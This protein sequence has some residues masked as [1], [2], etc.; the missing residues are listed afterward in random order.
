MFPVYRTDRMALPVNQAFHSGTREFQT[1]R[2]KRAVAFNEQNKINQ[3]DPAFKGLVPDSTGS[4]ATPYTQNFDMSWKPLIPRREQ[5]MAL[6]E[7]E[8][9][10]RMMETRAAISGGFARSPQGQ[11][12]INERLKQKAA[13]ATKL[14]NPFVLGKRIRKA[15][16][17][18]DFGKFELAQ[19]LTRLDNTMDTLDA[20]TL[21][22]N[23]EVSDVID[24]IR[25]NLFLLAPT[26]TVAEAQNIMDSIGSILKKAEALFGDVIG[27]DSQ[28]LYEMGEEYSPAKVSTDTKKLAT[29]VTSIRKL[30]KFAEMIYGNASKTSEA[31]RSSAAIASANTLFSK[32]EIGSTLKTAEAEIERWRTTSEQDETRMLEDQA[33]AEA[34]EAELE[35]QQAA[36]AGADIP[37][38]AARDTAAAAADVAR[39][40]EV[41]VGGPGEEPTVMFPFTMDEIRGMEQGNIIDY[42]YATFAMGPEVARSRA[43][44]N[45]DVFDEEVPAAAALI[46]VP[47]IPKGAIINTEEKQR[48]AQRA[49][50][51][52]YNTNIKPLLRPVAAAAAVA[53]APEE[54]EPPAE[55]KLGESEDKLLEW[56]KYQYY[57]KGRTQPQISREL[58]DKYGILYSQPT[59]SRRLKLEPRADYKERKPEYF[60]K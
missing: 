56:V 1:A 52:Y 37:A 46:D 32:A 12:Y 48:S 23:K 51:Q 17:P 2:A 25:S 39:T 57:V 8:K 26:F 11:A 22:F 47:G 24:S 4:W 16:T 60:R 59:I 21:I 34:Y 50:R 29:F 9:L 55:P 49:A 45:G 5:V 38:F 43:V 13:Q 15:L 41:P 30:F 19:K 20:Y 31:E 27:K 53:A 36:Q 3:R 14:Q 10:G 44:E 28:R 54:A 33:A 6:Y 40:A 18:A 7:Q 42:I 58:K 35:A